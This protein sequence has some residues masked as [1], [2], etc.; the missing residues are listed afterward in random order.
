MSCD[1][2]EVSKDLGKHLLLRDEVEKEKE[3][4]QEGCVNRRSSKE[5]FFKKK[6]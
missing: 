4:S 1:T 3:Q 6:L 2:E 5:K